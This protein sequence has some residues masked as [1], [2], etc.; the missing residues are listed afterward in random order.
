ME[1]EALYLSQTLQVIDHN[2]ETYGKQVSE[3][4]SEIEQMLEQFHDDNPEL[5]NTLEN[6]ITL[7]DHMKRALERNIKAKNKP[8]FGRIIFQDESLHK[9]ES[10]YIGR[11]GI[12]KD[13]THLCVIDWRAPVANIYYENGLGTCSYTAPD[14]TKM[15]IDLQLKR[16]YEI[17]QGKLIQY[18][19]TEVVSND[20]LL[21]K[22]LSKNKET[23]LGE[24]VATIQKEQ[25][26]IIRRN[27]YHNIIVQGAAGS[28][29]T[30]VAMHRISYILYNYEERFKPQDFYI[31]GSNRMLLQYITG[32]LPDLDVYG[33]KQMTMEQLFVRL[34]YE[35]WKETYHIKQVDKTSDKGVI[36]STKAWFDALEAYCRELEWNTI[37]RSSVYLNPLQF[38]E[39]FQDEK[40]G[41]FDRSLTQ[42]THLQTKILLA[43]QA[44][45]K[46]YIRQNPT[47]SLQSKINTLNERLWNRLQEEFIGKDAVYTDKE[48]KAI[49]KAYRNR[50]GTKTWKKSIFS[51]YKDFLTIQKLR[52]Y[53]VEIPKDT[54]DVYDLAALAY[55]YKRIKETEVIREASSIILDEAQDF[56]MMVY[57]VMKY[58]IKDC[59]YTIMGDVSQNIQFGYGLADW[60]EM[61]ELFLTTDRASFHVLKKSYRNTIEISR[62]A[63]RILQH[64]SFTAYSVEPIIRHGE[65]A[66]VIEVKTYEHMTQK[67]VDICKEWQKKG[68]ETIAIIC[69]TEEMASQVA[70]VLSKDLPL[71]ES[72]LETAEFGKGIMVLPAAYTKGLEFD[73]VL[74][75]N[76]TREAYPVDDG[77]TKLLYVAAT[78][79]LHELCI[80]YH[81]ALTGL[82]QDPVS[83]RNNDYDMQEHEKAACQT[84]SEEAVILEVLPAQK[85]IKEKER[86]AVALTK[87]KVS[88]HT[89]DAVA[90]HIRT[91]GNSLSKTAYT[92]YQSPYGKPKVNVQPTA[93]IKPKGT[94]LTKPKASKNTVGKAFGDIPATELLRTP[95]YPNI[96]RSIIKMSKQKDGLYLESHYGMMRLQAIQHSIIRITF[97]RTA[98][99]MHGI[100]PKMESNISFDT[101]KCKDNPKTV[102][103]ATKN[104]YLQVDKK[105]GAIR[106]L[107]N[108]KEK[109]MF[110]EDSLSP[111]RITERDVNGMISS[112]MYMEFAKGEHV[113]AH[114]IAHKCSENLRGITRYISHGTNT[115]DLPLLISDRGYGI[116]FATDFP[117]FFCDIMTYGSFVCVEDA[118]LDYYIIT[119]SDPDDIL[120]QYYTLIK[121]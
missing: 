72:S 80:L 28:G 106:Y 27:P 54:F 82:I 35:D 85:T 108:Q 100:H 7:H 53:D 32:A 77:H 76:P 26:D 40:V 55:I 43:D 98:Q 116:V 78:R 101:W 112:R 38:V 63:S 41:G 110:L 14:R 1:K 59:T 93:T 51:L 105:T 23:V 67:A 104:I 103:F 90:A 15:P 2:I 24:I 91:A 89:Q 99:L 39:G 88:A 6:T 48:K 3:M 9:Q 42:P 34:L 109:Q 96:D 36:R 79:A 33:V 118:K 56:G 5:I 16:T 21:T 57:S 66:A 115:D 22:Y 94:V 45:I 25:N 49:L 74:I 64:G 29:K 83:E 18:F 13:A 20:E 44:T 58:C 73:A 31:I 52:G 8:Y 68:L 102:D 62:F 121:N 60:E 17:E 19:D 65:E 46:Q 47:I 10:L 113:Y 86:A 37:D 12:A 81:G 30:T 84:S 95:A 119:G 87:P 50:Y 75:W 70:G 69:R 92:M 61:K 107:H 117:A 4:G 11:G 120:T 97:S 71:L 111:C 114:R